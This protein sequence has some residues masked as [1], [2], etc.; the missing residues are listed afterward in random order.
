MSTDS[1]IW[2]LKSTATAHKLDHLRQV[3]DIQQTSL[4]LGVLLLA[5]TRCH[6]HSLGEDQFLVA[7][8]SVS[9]LI[10]TDICA[11]SLLW[12]PEFELLVPGDSEAWRDLEESSSPKGASHTF[13]LGRGF[14]SVQ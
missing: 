2:T 7:V 9:G 12:S 6:L 14:S 8:S 1:P 5:A 10:W 4:L 11:T 13:A 3:S